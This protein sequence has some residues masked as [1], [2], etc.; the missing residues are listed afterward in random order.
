MLKIQ[1]QYYI[2]YYIIIPTGLKSIIC[3]LATTRLSWRYE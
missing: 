3:E 1:F 2:I